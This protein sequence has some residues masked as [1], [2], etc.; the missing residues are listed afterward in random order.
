M[1]SEPNAPVKVDVPNGPSVYVQPG[2]DG[3][4]YLID[5]AHMGT[6]YDRRKLVEVCGTA[7]DQCKIDWAGMIVTQP[8]LLKWTERRLLSSRPLLPDKTHAAGLVALKIVA[9]NG[10]PRFEP[11]WQAP[12]FSTQESRV[13]F[14]YHPTRV[15]VAPFGE[16]GEEYAWVGDMNFALGVRVRDGLIV[17]RQRMIGWRSRNS[18]PLIHDNVLYIP[19]CKLDDGPSRLEAYA[20]GR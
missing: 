19:T 15:V 18:L 13:R 17:E 10:T 6:L 12:D 5:A 9:V 11:F 2:K 3:S 14:R 1:T 7:E 8:T 4:V 16:A 20:I